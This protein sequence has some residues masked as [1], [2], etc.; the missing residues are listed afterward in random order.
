M[1]S[2]V[3]RKTERPS[4]GFP[5]AIIFFEHYS[6][7]KEARDAFTKLRHLLDV[8]IAPGEDLKCQVT[9]NGNKFDIYIAGLGGFPITYTDFTE[10]L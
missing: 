9:I 1:Y 7:I 4:W 3:F 8:E 6:T 5:A 2:I 10:C